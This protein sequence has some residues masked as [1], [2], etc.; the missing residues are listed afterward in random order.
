MVSAGP[1]RK[2]VNDMPRRK[3]PRKCSM[4][5]GSWPTYT[6][7]DALRDKRFSLPICPSCRTRHYW[8]TVFDVSE[9]GVLPPNLRGYE[10]ATPHAKPRVVTVGRQVG[11]QGET[12]LYTLKILA[13]GRPHS[14]AELAAPGDHRKAIVSRL[15]RMV[16]AGTIR[17]TLAGWMMNDH[18]QSRNSDRRSESSPHTEAL[19]TGERKPGVKFAMSVLADGR[20]H[21]LSELALHGENRQACE[22]RLRRLRCAGQIVKEGRRT[23]RI[24]PAA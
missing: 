9:G 8:K 15:R 5:L 20:A 1:V 4:C 23:W 10:V 16:V 21:T 14:I 13:D 2:E 22:S 24:T 18:K 11:Y 12:L 17:K 7:F 3:K 6:A 19:K